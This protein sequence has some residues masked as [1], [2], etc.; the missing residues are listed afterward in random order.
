M[1]VAGSDRVMQDGGGS[2]GDSFSSS[3]Y[4]R[5]SRKENVSETVAAVGPE[6]EGES[7]VGPLRLPGPGIG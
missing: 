1:R 6:K 5:V 2:G 3:E 7:R 4:R